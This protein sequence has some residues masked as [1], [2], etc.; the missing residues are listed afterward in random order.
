MLILHTSDWHLGQKF[1]NQQSRD[2]EQA[3]VLDWLLDAIRQTGAEALVVAGDVFDVHNP[4]ISAERLYYRF[5]ND[6][7]T[8]TAC[9]HVVIVGGNHDSP[10]KL[11]A[12]RELL[13]AFDIHVMGAAPE[14]PAET[15]LLL[16]DAAGAPALLVAA[17]PFLRERDVGVTQAGETVAERIERI[18]SG[19]AAYYR[20]VAEAVQAKLDE[21]GQKV[22]VLVTGHLVATGASSSGEQ[23]NIYLGNLDNI[24]AE[25]FSDVFDYVALGHIHSPQRVAKQS[26]IRYCGSLIP[27]SFGE[28]RDQKMALLAEL[29]PDAGLKAVTEL[30]AP[31]FRRLV[32][33]QGDF[34]SLLEQIPAFHD[35]EA[36]LPAWLKITV[37]AKDLPVDAHERLRALVR[38]LHLEILRLEIDRSKITGLV[39]AD[40]QPLENLRL[41]PE[42][43]VFRRRCE[44]E[45]LSDQAQTELLATY[46]E[47]RDW[48]TE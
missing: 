20:A 14:A 42:E 19:I 16:R 3:A 23:R 30:T 37:A 17:V 32:E 9:R 34:E 12:P 8:T 26:R 39:P 7:K 6:L 29:T 41:L 47:L 22:P 11:N 2:E 1:N 38:D 10:S 35:P 18:R 43:T 31:V 28:L 4:P 24:S 5:L 25:D 46:R 27:L 48:M 45:G 40:A 33:L 36:P 15:L 44:A 13:R 21:L